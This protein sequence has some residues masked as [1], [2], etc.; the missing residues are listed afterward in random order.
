MLLEMPACSLLFVS[1]QRFL[2]DNGACLVYREAQFAAIEKL[3][4]R[5]IWFC[6]QKFQL[7]HTQTGKLDSLVGLGAQQR[8]DALQNPS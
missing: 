3:F 8:K 6:G 1:M 5:K 7:G 4:A 2:I